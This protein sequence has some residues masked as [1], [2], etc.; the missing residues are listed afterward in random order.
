MFKN[1]VMKLPERLGLLPKNAPSGNCRQGRPWVADGQ[2]KVLEDD[3]NLAGIFLGK[4]GPNYACFLLAKLAFEIRE[5]CNHNRGV[6]RSEGGLAGDPQFRAGCVKRI[7][8]KV[9]KRSA[10]HALPVRRYKE[11]FLLAGRTQV[12]THGHFIESFQRG[13]FGVTDFYS[14]LGAPEQQ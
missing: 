3:A 1:P 5:D 9:Q 13:R 12:P 14:N 2:R 4:G 10:Y 11:Y 8:R 7:L 6:F